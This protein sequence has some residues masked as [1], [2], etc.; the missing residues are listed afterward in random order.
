MHEIRAETSLTSQNMCFWVCVCVRHCNCVLIS[1][2]GYFYLRL[3]CSTLLYDAVLYWSALSWTQCYCAV[4]CSTQRCSTLLRC[5]LLFPA[6]WCSAVVCCHE[7]SATVRS[8][9]VLCYTLLYRCVL[10]FYPTMILWW[11]SQFFRNIRITVIEKS[12][13][14]YTEGC[15][16]CSVSPALCIATCYCYHDDKCD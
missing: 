3:F 5:A 1:P 13:S 15:C 12:C 16:C 8:C 2:K 7:L 9:A 14:D 11:F 10:C 4:L 6:L